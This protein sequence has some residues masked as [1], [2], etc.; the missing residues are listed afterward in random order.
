M[1]IFRNFIEKLVNYDYYKTLVL[2]MLQDDSFHNE[3]DKASC[4]HA[5]KKLQKVDEVAKDITGKSWA[6]KILCQNVSL[7]ICLITRA[8]SNTHPFVCLCF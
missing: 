8:F 3:T 1:Q 6:I 2:S 5:F 7:C 4:K